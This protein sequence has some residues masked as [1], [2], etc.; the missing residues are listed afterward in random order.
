MLYGSEST[1]WQYGTWMTHFKKGACYIPMDKYRLKGV[2][3]GGG[4]AASEAHIDYRIGY[5]DIW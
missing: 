4:G 5:Y 1:A 3:L 2:I